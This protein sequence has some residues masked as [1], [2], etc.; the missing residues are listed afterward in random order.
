MLLFYHRSLDRGEATGL[1]LTLRPGP[2]DV[3][4]DERLRLV[5]KGEADPA[6]APVD[7]EKPAFHPWDMVWKNSALVLVR[8]SRSSRNSIAST[9]GMSDRKFR[10][11]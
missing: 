6:L 11:R 3:R 10:S 4:Q 2:F 8:F 1:R 7:G 5:G 9:G